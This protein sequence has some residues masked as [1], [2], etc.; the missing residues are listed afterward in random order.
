MLQGD[1][2]GPASDVRPVGE[3]QLRREGEEG[4]VRTVGAGE[5]HQED[6]LAGPDSPEDCDGLSDMGAEHRLALRRLAHWNHPCRFMTAGG[7]RLVMQDGRAA[8]ARIALGD[9]VAGISGP[10]AAMPACAETG[11]H[12]VRVRGEWA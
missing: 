4:P 7:A 9:L 2:C 5:R 1:I 8:L 10:D 11:T 6:L 12:G 3:W